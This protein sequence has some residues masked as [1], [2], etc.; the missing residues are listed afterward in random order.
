MKTR[1]ELKQAA[2]PSSTEH[3]NGGRGHFASEGLGEPGFIAERFHELFDRAPDAMV[4]CDT[5]G[6]IVA[7]NEQA[8]ELFGCASFELTGKNMQELVPDYSRDASGIQAGVDGEAH[9][10]SLF[11]IRKDGSE[12]PI[13]IGLS[14][15]MAQERTIVC[16]TI[17]RRDGS[18]PGTPFHPR[19]EFERVLSELSTKF[20]NL[21]P[22]RIDAEITDGLGALAEVIGLDRVS[23]AVLD[24]KGEDLLV[25]HSW[26]RSGTPQFPAK[27]LHLVLPWLASRIKSGEPVFAAG[28]GELP[29][30]AQA[31][32]RHMAT[33]GLKSTM[34]LPFRVGGKVTGALACSRRLTQRAWRPAIIAQFQT[35]ANVFASALARKLADEKLRRSYLEIRELKD[36]L[37]RENSYLREEIKLEQSHNAVIGESKA[38]RAVLKKAE[39]VAQTDSTVLILGETGTGKELIARTI[40]EMSGRGKR[41]MV[42]ANCAALP[43]SLIESELFG[44]EKGAYTGALAKEI[45]RFELADRST[46][47]LDE[48][49][50][51]PPEVQSKL[52]RILQEGEFERLGS[53][54]TIKVD[55][56]VIAATNRDLQSMVREGKFREDLFYRLNVFPIVVP[57]LRERLED[58][59]A[60]VW[61]ILNEMGP[62]MGRKIEGIHAGTMLAFQRYSW[63]GNVRELRNVIERNLILNH[64]PM[65]RAD[66]PE[67]EQNR[68][69]RLAAS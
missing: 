32:K 28:S 39:Q 56:R 1:N 65:F 29:P 53:P 17:H 21:A 14:S 11:A 33:V 61:H 8:A 69:T 58:I 30:E 49:G 15:L 63:P 6:I 55:V 57:P 26:A 31:E 51:L 18:N 42:K 43:A 60:L 9:R 66:L 27:S 50:E 62:R 20:I 4:I 46:L 59:P 35:A 36:Q 23:I 67:L 41:S 3:S 13:E 38:M 48:V 16:A 34:I 64:G 45:G 12:I 44:R 52:L 68:P 47:F 10:G 54:R 19:G 37:E 25:T 7:L 22:D 24:E 5:D 2:L 40:H